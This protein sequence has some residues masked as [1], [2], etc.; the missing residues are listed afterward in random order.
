[1]IKYNCGQRVP[2]HCDLGELRGSARVAATLAT[3][4]GFVPGPGA[5]RVIWGSLVASACCLLRF[6]AAPP[7]LSGWPVN[8]K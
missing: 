7:L 2:C 8:N 5:L 3:R 4:S 6:S 1:M